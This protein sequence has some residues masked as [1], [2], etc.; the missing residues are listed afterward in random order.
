MRPHCCTHNEHPPQSLHLLCKEKGNSQDARA[1]EM[2]LSSLLSDI[3]RLRSVPFL[4][5]PPEGNTKGCIQ[6]TRTGLAHRHVSPWAPTPRSAHRCQLRAHC[7]PGHGLLLSGGEGEQGSLTPPC[8]IL[9]EG[10]SW[11]GILPGLGGMGGTGVKGSME[12]CWRR[13]GH[14]GS[15]LK[16][17]ARQSWEDGVQQSP[18]GEAGAHREGAVV[19]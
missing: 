13:Q 1:I 2:G 5:P 6:C 10:R 11:P 7:P 3:Q 18:E 17:K 15:T 12:Q 9:A 4:P 19:V 8:P 16:N 14:P